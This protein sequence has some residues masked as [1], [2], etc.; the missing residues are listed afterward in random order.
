ML[1]QVSD[2]L[3]IL[4]VGL[5]A[6]DGPDILRMGKDDL[7][8]IFKDIE[9]GN[10]ILAGGF[11]TDVMAIVFEKPVTES[12]EVGVKRRERLLR[13]RCDVVLV[14]GSDGAGNRPLVYINAATDGVDDF[15][16]ITSF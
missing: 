10:P 14:R 15:H 8:M 7:D 1:E 3:G 16:G 2:P 13:I 6:L 11:H 4:L 9:D 5:L 12:I